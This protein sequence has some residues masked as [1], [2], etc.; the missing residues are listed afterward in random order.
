M[1]VLGSDP[2]C[3]R[4]TAQ[5]SATVDACR[6]QHPRALSMPTVGMFSGYAGTV[7]LCVDRSSSPPRRGVGAPREGNAANGSRIVCTSTMPF[8]H[9]TAGEG[10]DPDE[11]TMP[12]PHGP[13]CPHW[14]SRV[15]PSLVR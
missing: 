1:S 2:P 13:L 10:A 7:V 11:H 15:F 9:L 14:G 5:I 8:S 6:L 4:T 12:G 3:P